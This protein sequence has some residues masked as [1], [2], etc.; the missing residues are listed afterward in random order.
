[1]TRDFEKAG[2]SCFLRFAWPCA[3]HKYFVD[4]RMS[5]QDY[6]ALAD[7]VRTGGVPS[8]ELLERC[9]PRAVRELRAYAESKK[10]DMWD[11]EVVREFWRT[12]HRGGSPVLCAKV[13]AMGKHDVIIVELDGVEIR[14]L[15]PYGL[16]LSRGDGVFVHQQTAIEK[17]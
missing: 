16:K 11:P 14:V 1:V 15:N 10:K 2:R 3:W 4:H 7:L 9:Y 17:E 8:A 13:I 12:G 5:K 6:I